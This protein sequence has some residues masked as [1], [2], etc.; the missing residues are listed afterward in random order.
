M[1]EIDTST[2]KQDNEEMLTIV[3]KNTIKACTNLSLRSGPSDVA[4]KKTTKDKSVI[5]L[6]NFHIYTYVDLLFLLKLTASLVPH[7]SYSKSLLID[8]F[9]FATWN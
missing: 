3:K 6:K 7:S 8:Y 1:Q 2:S 5:E 4:P 9:P